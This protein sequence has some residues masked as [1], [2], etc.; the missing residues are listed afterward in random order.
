MQ[1]SVAWRRPLSRSWVA[2]VAYHSLYLG[3]GVIYWPH[4]S[5]ASAPEM[6]EL[7]SAEIVKSRRGIESGLP[8]AA[9]VKIGRPARVDQT[10]TSAEIPWKIGLLPFKT[11]GATLF[12]N[13]PV[14]I[15]K[16][17]SAVRSPRDFF[18]AF[19][20]TI[21]P[22]IIKRGYSGVV[23][24]M[25]TAL[26]DRRPLA[27]TDEDQ[28]TGERA[29]TV[30]TV[31][32]EALAWAIIITGESAIRLDDLVTSTTRDRDSVLLNEERLADR[33]DT[34]ASIIEQLFGFSRTKGSDA[35]F[36]EE[37]LSSWHE[38]SADLLA[39]LELGLRDLD[40]GASEVDEATLALLENR[41][42][43]LL[44]HELLSLARDTVLDGGIL[45]TKQASR[46]NR[47]PAHIFEDQEGSGE[48]TSD[49]WDQ[50]WQTFTPGSDDIVV[51]GRDYDYAAK[52]GEVFDPATGK[53]LEALTDPFMLDVTVRT[54]EANPFAIPGEKRRRIVPLTALRQLFAVLNFFR[55]DAIDNMD[56]WSVEQVLQEALS[57]TYAAI[58][59]RFAGM[60]MEPYYMRAFRLIRWYAEKALHDHGRYELA[61][62]FVPWVAPIPSGYLDMSWEG[63]GVA[64]TPGAIL[65]SGTGNM[66]IQVSSQV[67]GD[68][69]IDLTVPADATIGMAGIELSSGLQSVSVP[70]GDPI[71][72]VFDAPGEPIEI[73]QLERDGCWLQEY[74]ITPMISA[75]AALA[76][77]D[78]WRALLDQYYRRHHTEKTKGIRHIPLQN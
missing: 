58:Q 10:D 53:V 71:D 45:L 55:N 61:R 34:M 74:T 56:D 36:I 46:L 1:F 78:Y 50:I 72:L 21:R 39:N 3:V 16:I 18:R 15:P 4:L 37:M 43:R 64:M 48:S 8:P 38:V 29:D 20:E 52:F 35:S 7:I 77:F 14:H 2:S 70:P 25:V 28:E 19:Q 5:W 9:T 32:A 47:L 62:S 67:Y 30:A 69:R 76:A 27:T 54:P 65:L 75:G 63:T 60:A 42:A 6:E 11:T 17:E 73:R 49:P 68:V 26:S 44:L 13:R 59:S 41:E 40:H 66:R 57:F 12:R 33:I 22:A 23:L 31:T 24:S 51:P